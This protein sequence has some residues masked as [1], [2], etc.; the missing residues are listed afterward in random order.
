MQLHGC[1]VCVCAGQRDFELAGEEG[2]FRV[3]C[4]PLADDFGV[5]PGIFDLIRRDPGIR[6]CG[7]VSDAISRCLQGVHLHL[8]QFVEE[9]GD[10]DKFRPV[11]LDVLTR[12]EMPVTLVIG[13]CNMGEGPHL[14]DSTACRTGSRPA[15]CRRAAAGTARSSSRSGLNSSSVMSPARRRADL[16]AEL[17]DP[18]ADEGV[19]EFVVAVHGSSAFRPPGSRDPGTDRGA[20]G[21]DGFAPAHRAVRRRDRSGTGS[22]TSLRSAACLPRILERG[23]LA[24][25]S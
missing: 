1:P 4:R 5:D 14:F 23:G 10:V 11:V 19:I 25:S 2:E 24:S 6:V 21:A 13:A 16:F 18:F 20:G 15:T 3:Q 8:C 22:A 9:V 12:R 7:D 17:V